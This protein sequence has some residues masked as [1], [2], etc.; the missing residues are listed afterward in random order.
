MKEV[1]VKFVNRNQPNTKKTYIFKTWFD[2][3]KIND[4]VVVDTAYGLATA[5]V[6]GMTHGK[7]P[8]QFVVSKIDTKRYEQEK[9]IEKQEQKIKALKKEIQREVDKRHK[10]NRVK[11]IYTLF[12]L[13][14]A[15]KS[16]LSVFKLDPS[17]S[18]EVTSPSAFDF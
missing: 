7:N 8:T 12:S 2:D 13:L 6:C 17:E 1:A 9:R 10:G 4:L 18:R 11:S 15:E 16:I 14:E 3:L 5:Q